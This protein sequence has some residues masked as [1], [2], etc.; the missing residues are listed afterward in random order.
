MSK[1][2]YSIACIDKE[3]C[4]SVLDPF[5]YLTSVSKGFKL[6]INIG[7]Y[8]ESRIAGL[9]YRLLVGVI[10]FTGFP[11][12]ELSVG[13]LG[14]ERTDQSGLWELSRLC[15]KPYEQKTEHNLASWFVSRAIKY[16]KRQEEVRAILSYADTGYHKGTIYRACNFTYYGLTAK[17]KDFWIKNEEGLF[18]KQSRGRTKGIEGEWRDRTQ[19]HRFVILYDKTLEMKWTIHEYT[20]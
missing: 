15:I 16:L 12:P 18:T 20:T 17:K 11:T 9:N 6:G 5:H 2:E 10:I 1:D 3:Q 7:L 19:K 8:K 13:M 14:L 4:K